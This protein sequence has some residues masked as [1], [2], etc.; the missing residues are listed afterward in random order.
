[1]FLLQTIILW[2]I[3]CDMY[4]L[5]CGYTQSV[6]TLTLRKEIVWNNVLYTNFVVNLR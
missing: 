5:N 4:I 6:K 2:Y 3:L 1:M